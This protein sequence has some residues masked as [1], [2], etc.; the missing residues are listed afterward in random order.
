MIQKMLFV[1]QLAQN[2]EGLF[3]NNLF[4]FLATLS[5]ITAI[6]C[7]SYKYFNFSNILGKFTLAVLKYFT[8]MPKIFIQ[9]INWFEGFAI[10]TP[11]ALGIIILFLLNEI[12]HI[13]FNDLKYK[14]EK[15]NEKIKELE[16]QLQIK[17]SIIEK[18]IKRV[19]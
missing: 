2:Q 18:M 19:D 4:A 7:S 9:K 17:D 15:N 5:T 14:M 11:I 3:D 10:F 13:I 16:E 1:Q 8:A 12:S 6:I